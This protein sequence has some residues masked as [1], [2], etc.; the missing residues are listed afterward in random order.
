M[1]VCIATYY[2]FSIGGVEKYSILKV[3]LD[4][5]I[6]FLERKLNDAVNFSLATYQAHVESSFY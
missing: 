3:V 1:N 2:F 5:G 6:V 4:V